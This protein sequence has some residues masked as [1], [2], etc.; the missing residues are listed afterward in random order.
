MMNLKNR[1]GFTLIEVL[2]ALGMIGL[3]L[4]PIFVVQST[5]MKTISNY[6]EQLVRVFAGQAFLGQMHMQQV[7]DP[8][9]AQETKKI[10]DPESTLEYSFDDID[11]QSSLSSFKDV[12]LQE[13]VV[14]WDSI[15]GKEQVTLATFF[16]DPEQE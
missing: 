11:E 5:V 12:G 16:Y 13:V 9:L 8:D 3:V 4:T 1:D 7:L 10:D 2:I 15:E 14:N 6:S